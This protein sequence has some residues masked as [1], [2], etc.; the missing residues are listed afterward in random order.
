MTFYQIHEKTFIFHKILY[1]SVSFNLCQNPGYDLLMTWFN[2]LV[3]G[4]KVLAVLSTPGHTHGCVTYV[5]RHDDNPVLVF[6]GDALLIRGCGRTDF[7]EG[8]YVRA[9][10]V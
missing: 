3:F 8:M 9:V 10:T 7:Q 2:N 6:T 4:V 5:L 1:I